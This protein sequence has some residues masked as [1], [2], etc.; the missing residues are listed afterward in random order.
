MPTAR[1]TMLA[2]ASGE[3]KTR[4][5]P[6]CRCS[7]CVTLKTPP[8][9]LTSASAASCEA[10]ATSSPNTTMRSSRAISSR[11]QA[12]SRSTMVFGASSPGAGAAA[13]VAAV[14]STVGRVDPVRPALR[15]RLRLG[16]RAR[17]RLVDL[18][19]HLRLD[20]LQLRLGDAVALA[21]Q[22]RRAHDRIAPRLV[23]ALRRGLVQPLVVRQRVRVRPHDVSVHERRAR[24]RRAA[25]PP[26]RRG[27]GATRGSRSRRPRGSSGSGT[28][29]AASRSSRR[30]VCASTGTE[31][32]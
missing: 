22:R 28:S 5:E 1:P 16:E 11:R 8:L 24:G 4:R 3:L 18:G 30:A 2:S 14:G 25:P 17:R 21:Q 26:P 20:A 9:P 19:D 13:N 29:A 27:R 6:N 7:P 31:I 10:S 15:R 23:L 12:L 32:A